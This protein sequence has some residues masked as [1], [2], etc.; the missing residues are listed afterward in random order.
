M[1]EDVAGE[2]SQCDQ[3]DRQVA[4]LAGHA[5]VRVG[6]AERGI[7]LV[8]L[9]LQRA[10]AFEQGRR[11]QRLLQLL[12]EGLGAVRVEGQRRFAAARLRGIG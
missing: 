4:L 12:G 9:G 3:V 11:A 7:D 1:L 8:R 10:P 6:D 5:R 2:G